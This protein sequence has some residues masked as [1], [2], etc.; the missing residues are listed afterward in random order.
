MRSLTKE[1]LLMIADETLTEHMV[2]KIKIKDYPELETIIVP[3]ANMEKKRED[4]EERY[5]DDLYLK[6][7][8][9]TVQIKEVIFVKEER[10]INE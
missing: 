9:K 10:F 8:N 2:L 3:R 6:G 7:S 5:N 4:I 1:E